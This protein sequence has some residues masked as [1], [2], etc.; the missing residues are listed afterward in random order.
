PVTSKAHNFYLSY[1]A[2][3]GLS[4]FALLLAILQRVYAGLPPL[5]SRFRAFRVCFLVMALMMTMN[6]YILLPE[7]WLFFGLMNGIA[8]HRM[9]AA[10]WMPGAFPTLRFVPP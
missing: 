3:L 6:E 4:G 7:L 1:F 10:A 5:S 8:R 9:P 2:E